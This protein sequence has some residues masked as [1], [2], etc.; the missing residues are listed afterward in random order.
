M[1]LFPDPK[2]FIRILGIDIAWYAVIILIGAG[3]ALYFT[4]LDGKKYN[5]SK[6]SIIDMF[7]E[8]LMVGIVGARLWYVLF[9]PDLKDFIANPMSILAFRDGGLAIQGGIVA[10]VIYAYFRCK[11]LNV[12]FINLADSAMPNLLIAQAIGRW[13]NF[14]NQEAFGN[15]VTEAYYKYFPEWF[16]AKMYIN[17]EYR[18][19]MFFYESVLN[20]LGFV[21][22]KFVLPKYRKMKSG[23]YVYAYLVWYGIVRIG[24]EHFRTDSLVFFG[25]KSAQVTSVIFIII[26]LLGF[27]GLFRKNEKESSKPLVLFDFDGTI[28]HTN[29]L[30]LR[31]FEMV[32]NKH[33]PEIDVNDEMKDTFIGPTLKHTFN[34]YLDVD[35]VSM[36]VD[37]YKEI[38]MQMQKEELVEIKNATKLLKTL[39][40]N[41]ATL[42]V[43]SSK[44][45]DSL[46]LGI[47]LLNFNEY[48]SVIIGGDEVK[49]PKPNPEGIL[50]AKNEVD[51]TTTKNYY[52]GDTK[53]DVLAAKEA[54]FISIVIVTSVR[55]E[56]ELL[57]CN[58]DYVIY[59]LLEVL[60]I[61]KE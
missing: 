36:Y 51:P 52:V 30:I 45:R 38:N 2:V 61:I 6:D 8:V 4:I 59:D 19:P 1:Q 37:E 46:Q 56:A 53:T 55:L 31:T 33:F 24:I 41:G 43:V 14:V 17:G 25:L 57:S 42:G 12:N 60:D 10:A 3:V 58:A 34:R 16:K 26:G 32:F 15:V 18:Q 48:L 20:L 11:K 29:P 13:G 40:N 50:R 44:M 28:A 49:H 47:D 35:D 21:L 27:Q 39:K 23:D 54:G 7:F 22:I 5:I 9:H